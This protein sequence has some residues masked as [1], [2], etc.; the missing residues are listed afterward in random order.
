MM[1]LLLIVLGLVV[2]V[3]YFYNQVVSLRQA[4]ISSEAEISIQL[5]R[6]GKVFDSLLATVKKYLAHES[7]VFTKI[8][9]LRTQAQ[10]AHPVES[11]AA[12]EE[13]SRV[14]SS[15]AIQMAVENYPDLKSDQIMANLQ[16]EIVSTE[17]KLSFAKRG[18]NNTLE[19][20]QAYIGSMPALFIVKFFPQLNLNKDYWRL[21]EATIKAEEQRR[22]SFD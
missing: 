5:D 11:K 3:F 21:D 6:R 22:I 9:A 1:E 2:L 20:F 18:Y 12:E 8:T 4:V 15:G 14:V 13:L 16:E 7:E 17:N 19:K 10:Q